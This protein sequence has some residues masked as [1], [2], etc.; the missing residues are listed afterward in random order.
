[1][2]Y[3]SLFALQ[4]GAWTSE[5]TGLPTFTSTTKWPVLLLDEHTRVPEIIIG[6]KISGQAFKADQD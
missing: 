4:T 2:A 3:G 5:T 1:M 6:S